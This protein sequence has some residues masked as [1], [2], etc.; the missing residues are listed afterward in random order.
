MTDP[1]ASSPRPVS[2]LAVVAIFVLLSVFGLVTVRVY[3]RHRAPAPQNL[4]PDNLSKDL[5]WRSTPEARREA[6]AKLREAQ[7]HQGA[8]YAWVNQ[9]DGVVQLPIERAM[10]LVVEEHAGK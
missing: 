1:N 7:S 6:L 4:A 8:S 9:K 5:A 10:Q 3:T 2:L